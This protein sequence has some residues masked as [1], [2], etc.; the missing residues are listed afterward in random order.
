VNWVLAACFATLTSIS[1]PEHK[2]TR[3]LYGNIASTCKALFYLSLTR[4]LVSCAADNPGAPS[5]CSDKHLIS[6]LDAKTSKEIDVKLMSSPGFSIDQLMELAGLSVAT[7]VR[8]FSETETGNHKKRILIVCGPGNNGGDG[9]VAAR[10]L[11]HFGYA[12]TIFYPKPGKGTLF[13]NLISQCEDL[14]IPFISGCP[15]SLTEYDLVVDALFGFSFHGP[16]KA[17]FDEII[18]RFATSSIPIISVDIP[19]GWHVEKGDIYQ[20]NF[21]PAAIISLTAP[22]KCVQDYHGIHYLGGRYSSLVN[23]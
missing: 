13:V 14:N 20:T 15:D 17:P 3:H 9:L 8:D 12:P 18:T 1:S 11:V 16:T 7:A 6:Y 4:N 19:S 5:S 10:H 22:K 2:L 21:T 23:R